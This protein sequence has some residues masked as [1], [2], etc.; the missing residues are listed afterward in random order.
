MKVCDNFLS[1]T[2]FNEIR[3]FIISEK[4]PIFF[5]KNV[6]NTKEENSYAHFGHA[7]LHL[8][9]N[10]DASEFKRIISNKFSLIEKKFIS[11]IPIKT[12]LRSKLN[13][14]PKT[15]TIVDHDL[16]KDFPF[17][18][19]GCILSLNTCNG[20]TRFEN[21]VKIE[22]IANRALFFDPSELHASSSCTDD[23]CRWNIIIN[24]L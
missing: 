20:Y 3:D 12:I 9:P 21:D 24:Y 4:F 1:E 8:E 22:S 5:Q 15:D 2:D 6:V 13:C 23:K 14:Y 17:S 7:F 11:K 18:H 16:H 19:T 10:H